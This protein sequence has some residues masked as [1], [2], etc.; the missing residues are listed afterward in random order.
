MRDIKTIPPTISIINYLA[1]RGYKIVLFT[2]HTEVKFEFSNIHLIQLKKKPYPIGLLKRIAAKIYFHLKFYRFLFKHK[3][4]VN[5][6]WLGAPDVIGIYGFKG[7]IKVVYQFHELEQH[8]FNSCR[9][10]DYLVVPEENR[11]WI[12]YFLA[13]LK[14]KPLLLPNIPNYGGFNISEDKEI[15]A[16]KNMGK[17]TVLYSGLIDNKKRSLKELVKAFDFLPA[18]YVLVIIPSFVKVRN[19]LEDLKKYVKSLN[20]SGRVVFLNSRMP[21]NHLNTIAAADIG[22]GFYSATSLNNVY[23]APNRLYEFVNFGTLLIL[24]DFPAFKALS[25][26]FPYAVNVTDISNPRE[27]S[28]II[29]DIMLNINKQK[30]HYLHLKRLKGTMNILQEM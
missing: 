2:Y 27:I 25:G 24:P 17:I 4:A 26:V 19:D 10:A 16:L 14:T 28:V 30:N 7:A 23:A 1:S 11:G 22:I 3:H 18:K 13:K 21:P 9:K 12:T 20:L 5:I 6:I 15:T 29:E 8:R